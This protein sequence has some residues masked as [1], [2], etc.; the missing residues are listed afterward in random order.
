MEELIVTAENAGEGRGHRSGN[1]V[2]GASA[3]LALAALA[4]TGA[5]EVFA[6]PEEAQLVG[7]ER[8]EAEAAAMDVRFRDGGLARSIETRFRL[9]GSVRRQVGPWWAL[10]M[11]HLGDVDGQKLVVGRDG[12]L[13]LRDRALMEP[14]AAASGAE[15][16]GGLFGALQRSLGRHESRL[17][18]LPL[19]RKAAVCAGQ[20]PAGLDPHASADRVVAGR[21]ARHGVAT[22]DLFDAWCSLEPRDVYLFRDS[23]WARAAR[24]TAARA[25][26]PLIPGSASGAVAGSLS[27]P[28]E[29][30]LSGMV[31]HADLLTFMGIPEEH[32]A[33]AA[34]GA[35]Q[36]GAISIGGGPMP[37]GSTD[38]PAGDAAPSA[39]L[40]GSSF[41]ARFHFQGTLEAELGVRVEDA[42]EAGRLPFHCLAQ[43]LVG[44]EAAVPPLVIAEFPIH[45]AAF[46]R[47]TSNAILQ[48]AAAVLVHLNESLE[49]T[50]IGRDFLAEGVVAKRALNL[51]C[52]GYRAG[53][54]L[55]SGDG[56]LLVEF[57]FSGESAST[58]FAASGGARFP[59]AV[60][61]GDSRVVLPILEAE[62]FLGNLSLTPTNEA[63]LS[64]E[65][66]AQIVT[67]LALEDASPLAGVLTQDVEGAARWAFEG[68]VRVEA[69]GALVVEWSKASSARWG[70]E[71]I[72]TDAAGEPVL[73]RWEVD[74]KGPRRW[75][76]FGLGPFEGGTLD[77]VCV[78]GFSGDLTVSLAP[79]RDSGRR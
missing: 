6:P 61:A 45:Q 19:P 62:D 10:A 69:H 7:D 1:L 60:A 34:A 70:L 59:I 33:F 16:L 38:G 71:L 67:D 79:V 65:F 73:R 66:T 76:A 31:L 72:G 58:W 30:P 5:V 74:R 28:R 43:A 22:P 12:W 77:E 2:R 24:S 18:V 29:G 49:F 42:S 75:G 13:F 32:P 51:P 54:L 52:W 3:V 20:L 40:V 39:L 35:T 11:L 48:P 21:L 15:V 56:V 57:R 41:S 44:R 26:R 55:S 78:T 14:A 8:A 25:L 9:R 37:H 53:S 47:R 63:A 17:V 4:W 64:T 50:P 36:E 27:G 23:H 68:E 46:V